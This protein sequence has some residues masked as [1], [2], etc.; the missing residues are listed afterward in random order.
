LLQYKAGSTDFTTVTQVEQIQVLQQDTLAQAEGEIVAGLIQVYRALGGGW[1]IRLQNCAEQ[2]PPPG[3]APAISQPNAE[4]LPPP[5]PG[6][7]STATPPAP[8][9]TPPQESTPPQQLQPPANP[10][11]PRS[12][13]PSTP[14]AS[15]TDPNSDAPIPLHAVIESASK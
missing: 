6:S 13:P 14:G 12:T 3:G 4:L 11:E 1:Q 15:T 5:V 9:V 7:G 10:A 8:A 2:L